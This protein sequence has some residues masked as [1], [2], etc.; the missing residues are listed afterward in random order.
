MKKSFTNFSCAAFVFGVFSMFSSPESPENAIRNFAG[1]LKAQDAPGI[2]QTMHADVITGKDLELSDVKSFLKQYKTNL[3]ELESFDITEKMKAEDGSAERLRTVIKFKGPTLSDY[4]SQPTQVGMEL[5]WLLDEKKWRVERIVNI[6]QTVKSAGNYPTA[7]QDE[8][9]ARFEAAVQVLEK[10]NWDNGPASAMEGP[11]AG[12]AGELLLDLE[13]AYQR[14]RNAKG[15]SPK[16]EGIQLL[17]R[18]A[19]CKGQDVLQIYYGDF[20]AGLSDK[21]KPMPW[22]VIQDYVKAAIEGA[23]Q[24]EKAGN[25]KKAAF[26]YRRIISLGRQFL[27]TPGGYQFLVWG[28]SFQKQGADQL[29]RIVDA[30]KQ[31][32]L[33]LSMLCGR[34]IDLLQTA[35]S[36]LN[37]FADYNCLKAA[38]I[39]ADRERDSV[40]RPW[41]L[42]TLAIL[43]IRGA[44]ANE[45]AHKT[46]GG[47]VLVVNPTMQ[48]KA[49]E[50]LEKY[51]QD[52]AGK[53][54][55]FVETQKEWIR[56]H[57]VYHVR[58]LN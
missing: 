3:F 8:C 10:T 21:R 55:K 40:F 11:E 41:G 28:S 58:N 53:T 36:C 19:G 16:A 45:A 47:V 26:V 51:A 37:D 9:G 43:A 38:V 42:N 27:N 22:K 18:A 13:K 14:E 2:L 56:S 54:N 49:V 35:M 5:I 15:L 46:A 20:Q 29:A 23:K 4:Q 30:E 44:P 48:Q 12:N 24:T 17:L 57:N 6:D 34:R 25:Y 52:S 7:A 1:L 50:T 31:K 39:A 32:A 33:E